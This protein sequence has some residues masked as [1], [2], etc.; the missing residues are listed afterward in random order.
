[1]PQSEQL[2]CSSSYLTISTQE[3]IAEHHQEM[4]DELFDGEVAQK[5]VQSMDMN[6][7]GKF[8]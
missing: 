7:Q 2:T 5:Q 3:V 6:W 8:K 1:L 4:A